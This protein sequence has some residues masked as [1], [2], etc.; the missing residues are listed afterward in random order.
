M[1]KYFIFQAKF[2]PDQFFLFWESV[3]DRFLLLV[4]KSQLYYFSPQGHQ[5]FLHH[6]AVTLSITGL[7]CNFQ[8]SHSP[9]FCTKVMDDGI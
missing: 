6:T 4:T 8:I 5:L 1:V 2:I 3:H 7:L 9:I